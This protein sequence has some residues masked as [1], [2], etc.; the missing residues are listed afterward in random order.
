MI[1]LHEIKLKPDSFEKGF[2]SLQGSYQ[3]NAENIR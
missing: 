3:Q 2:F 1:N